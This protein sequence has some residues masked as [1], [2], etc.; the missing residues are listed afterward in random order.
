[1]GAKEKGAGLFSRIRRE[2]GGTHE[3]DAL[4]PRYTPLVRFPKPSVSK[5]QEDRKT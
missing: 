2:G 5:L 1:M 3:E 4:S